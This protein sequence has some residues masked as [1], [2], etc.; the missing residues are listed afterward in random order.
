MEDTGVKKTPSCEQYGE[1]PFR[2]EIKSTAKIKMVYLNKD[3]LADRC[4]FSTLGVKSKNK[5]FLS[6][7]LVIIHGILGIKHG[8]ITRTG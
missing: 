1:E 6:V 5:N 3:T 2:K 4:S 7:R 8:S